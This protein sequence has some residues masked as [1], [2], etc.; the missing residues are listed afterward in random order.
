MNI[1]RRFVTVC[2]GL[3]ISVPVGFADSADAESRTRQAAQSAMP[4]P[5]STSLSKEE[6]KAIEQWVHDYK[7]WKAWYAKWRNHVEP[8][9]FGSTR[10]RRQRPDPPATLATVCPVAL[11]ESNV[12]AE[13]CRLFKEW[14]EDDLATEVIKQQVATTRAQRETE[15]KSVWWRHVHLD[16]VWP[17]TQGKSGV[18]GVVGLHTT[19]DISGRVELFLTPGAM[20]MRVPGPGGADQ[21][22]PATD[23]GMS[24]RLADFTIP[25]THRPATLHM[26]L[27]RVWLLGR[28]DDVPGVQTDMSLAGFSLTFRKVTH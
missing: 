18:W 20:L 24:F 14:R 2:A 11:D 7:K 25:G 1:R 4:S 3:L 17:L 26:N 13:A 28:M 23:W 22:K 10:D 21:W 16:A 5:T 19:I 8:G 15:D 12:L 27:A 6:M 9:L